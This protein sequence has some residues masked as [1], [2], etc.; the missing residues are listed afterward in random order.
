M[1]K[2][3]LDGRLEPLDLDE[4]TIFMCDPD[5]AEIASTLERQSGKK[6]SG[7][8]G[9]KEEEGWDQ[10]EANGVSEQRLTNLVI[11][12]DKIRHRMYTRMNEGNTR[13]SPMKAKKKMENEGDTNEVEQDDND[14]V[15]RE[16]APTPAA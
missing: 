1:V 4:E 5:P 6:K 12:L 8:K 9:G 7:S 15:M 16:A 10:V 11:S 3:E 13:W 2:Y 14:I